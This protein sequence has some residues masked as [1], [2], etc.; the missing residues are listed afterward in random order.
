[1]NKNLG[2]FWGVGELTLCLEDLLDGVGDE[3]SQQVDFHGVDPQVAHEV[4]DCDV[5][6]LVRPDVNGAIVLEF[7]DGV[8]LVSVDSDVE[9]I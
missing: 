5:V 9:G 1:M 6:E 3:R 8:E 4:L 2:S 7:E